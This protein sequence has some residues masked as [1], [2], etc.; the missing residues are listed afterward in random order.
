MTFAP[1]ILHFGG[2][3]QA[4]DDPRRRRGRGTDDETGRARL[5]NTKPSPRVTTAQRTETVRRTIAEQ[6]APVLRLH[7]QLTKQWSMH[8]DADHAR[9]RLRRGRPAFDPMR[10]IALLGA[11]GALE[12]PFERATAALER[13]WLASTEE[14]TEARKLADRV[15]PM[16][17]SWLAGEPMPRDPVRRTAMRAAVVVCSS[18]LRHTSLDLV[19]QLALFEW[20]RP[21]CPC[22]GGPPDLAICGRGARTL[23]CARC[24]ATWATSRT[25]CIGCGASG[26]PVVARVPS[27]SIGYALVICHSCGRYLKERDAGERIEPLLE[28]ILTSQLDEAAESRGLLLAP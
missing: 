16:G 25:G 3:R 12:R 6:I 23:V 9:G 21:T 17:R 11:A 19:P 18:L 28:R 5:P 13:S 27:P 22:C 20:T 26:A 7:T 24:D 4:R 15:V 2:S 14:S 10:L 1:L 8:L